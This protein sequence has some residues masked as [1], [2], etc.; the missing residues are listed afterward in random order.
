MK[1]LPQYYQTLPVIQFCCIL[2]RKGA[3]FTKILDILNFLHLDDSKL[4]DLANLWSYKLFMA[5]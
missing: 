3:I 4:R 5:D 1:M 2:A